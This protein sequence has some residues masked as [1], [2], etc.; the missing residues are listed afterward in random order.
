M[1]RFFKSVSARTLLAPVIGAISTLLV[2]AVFAMT[3]GGID[4]SNEKLLA[5]QTSIAELNSLQLELARGNAAL[6]QIVSWSGAH[7][8]PDKVQIIRKGFVETVARSRQ[9]LS[10]LGVNGGTALVASSTNALSVYA[11]AADRLL[12]LLDVDISLANMS[13]YEVGALYGGLEKSVAVMSAIMVERQKSVEQTVSADMH[14]MLLTAVGVV[15]AAVALGL[16]LGVGVARGIARPLRQLTLTMDSLAAGDDRVVIPA[17][18][19]DDEIGAMA[20]AVE[21]FKHNSQERRRLEQEQIVCAEKAQARALALDQISAQF[22]Q[23]AGGLVGDVARAA[24]RLQ[25]VSNAVHAIANATDRQAMAV[26]STSVQTAANVQTVA[27]AAE[28]LAAAAGEITHHAT[29]SASIAERAGREAAKT[30]AAIQGLAQTAARIDEI[31]QMISAIAGQTNLLALNATIE[32]S[33]AGET[34]KGF[35]VVAGE[36]KQL[37][38]GT[39]KA[40]KVI[41]D[42]VAD[43]QTQTQAVVEAIASISVIIGEMSDIAASISTAVEEQN[44]ATKDIARNVDQAALGINHVTATIGDVKKAAGETGAAAEEMLDA[45]SAMTASSGELGTIVQEFL[46]EILA[47]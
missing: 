27:S 32:A 40:T 43:V 45:A 20:R 46:E 3:V 13:L 17:T 37:A 35:A 12:D 29:H 2:G 16:G 38:T 36:I 25:A 10:A 44:A 26:A 28:E 6:Y 19:L 1:R 24:G 5:V 33:R 42:E 8:E 18:Q 7:I 9:H 14:H 34:G 30:Q 22:S 23:R 4:R 11:E 15:A 21:V 47:A 31:V 41:A 39:A